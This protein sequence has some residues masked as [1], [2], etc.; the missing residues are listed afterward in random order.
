M[1]LIDKD[2]ALYQLGIRKEMSGGIAMTTFQRAI[3]IVDKIPVVAV[4]E[5]KTPVWKTG[6]PRKKGPYLCCMAV[7]DNIWIEVCNY[8]GKGQWI[9]LDGEY[10]TADVTFWQELPDMP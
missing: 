2:I 8:A 5:E 3:E 1:K 9:Y 7:D 6:R 10:A 4:D